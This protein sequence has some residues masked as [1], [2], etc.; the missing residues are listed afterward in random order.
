MNKLDMTFRMFIAITLLLLLFLF[1]KFLDYGFFKSGNPYFIYL[2]TFS[3]VLAVLFFSSRL[4]YEKK[5][6]SL[7]MFISL[8]FSLY[9]VEVFLFVYNPLPWERGLFVDGYDTRTPLQ[10]VYDY[11]I[12]GIEVYPTMAV[13]GLAKHVVTTKTGGNV[14]PLSGVSNVKTI[15]CN[16]GDGYLEYMS[17]NYGFNNTNSSW[18]SEV[19]IA[20]I[21]DSFAQG[22]CLPTNRN[23]STNLSNFTNKNVLNLGMG[24]SGPLVELAILKEYL[25]EVKPNTVLWMYTEFNDLAGNIQAEEKNKELSNYIKPGHKNG[26]FHSQKD[27]NM[28]IKTY[29]NKWY[30]K[31]EA[32]LSVPEKKRWLKS[33]LSIVK[34]LHIRNVLGFGMVHRDLDVMINDKIPLFLDIVLEAKRS[35]E[36]WNGELV[37]VYITDWTR[38]KNKVNNSTYRFKDKLINNIKDLGIK[39]VDVHEVISLHNDP[40]SLFPLRI[41]SHYTQEGYDIVSQQIFDELY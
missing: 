4:S 7:I 20:L 35:V 34:L 29:I 41:N 23:I 17:D 15:Y 19:E 25:S 21:G 38:Y 2:L 30:K 37:F 1:V 5:A 3:F 22:A 16:E 6:T 28:F 40:L 36:E 9:I 24:S 11:R 26:N 10:V 39:V 33:T 27:I 13:A 14:T 8:T 32:R 18:E 31:N 12:S